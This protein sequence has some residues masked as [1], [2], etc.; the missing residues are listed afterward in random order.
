MNFDKEEMAQNLAILGEFAGLAVELKDTQEVQKVLQAVPVIAAELK[1]IVKG[2]RRFLTELDID[3]LKQMEEA[4]IEREYAV[5]ILI[6]EKRP[7]ARTAKAI[8]A[9]TGAKKK[10]VK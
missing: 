5:S 6:H 4:G 9:I 3:A 7:A 8:D 2:F 10:R 1:P